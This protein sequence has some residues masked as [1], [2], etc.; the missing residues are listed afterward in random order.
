L[1]VVVVAFVTSL[2]L[3]LAPRLRLPVAGL[4]LLRC[5]APVGTK[6]ASTKPRPASAI[7]SADDRMLCRSPQTTVE[8]TA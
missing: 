3:G 4:S 5:G 7:L 2:V 6:P 1:I 8:A